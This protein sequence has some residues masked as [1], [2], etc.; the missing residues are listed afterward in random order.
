[1][2]KKVDLI[3]NRKKTA[4]K[5][6]KKEIVK[7]VAKQSGLTQ[8]QVKDCFSTYIRLIESFAKMD[9]VPE[10]LKIEFPDLGYFQMLEKEGAKKGEVYTMPTLI[11]KANGDLVTKPVKYTIE[12]DRPNY[13]ELR[14]HLYGSNAKVIR[15]L[16]EERWLR[17]QGDE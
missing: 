1:M 10:K 7:L 15:A 8:D 12:E 11:K 13:Q 5:I 3:S 17:Q 4:P 14:F 2:E 16:S 6:T 9:N